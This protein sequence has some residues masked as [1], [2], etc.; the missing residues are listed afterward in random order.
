MGFSSEV[1]EEQGKSSTGSGSLIEI[2]H[3]LHSIKES[4][5]RNHGHEQLKGTT[6]IHP[7]LVQ[8]QA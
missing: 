7:F 8:H 2:G 4:L 3:E 1:S 6:E 5:N